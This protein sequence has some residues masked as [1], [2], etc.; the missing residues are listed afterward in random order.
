MENELIIGKTYIAS[1]GNKYVIIEEKTIKN[2]VK[3][4]VCFVETSNYQIT[5]VSTIRRGNNGL[6]DY[7]Y[8]FL[9]DVGYAIGT[10]DNPVNL[11]RDYLYT[12]WYNMILRC[13]KDGEGLKSYKKV[14]VCKEWHDYMN[15]KR[16]YEENNKYGYMTNMS[17]DKDLFSENGNKIYSP[18]TCCFIPKE[19]NACIVG[20]NKY[21]SGNIAETSSKTIYHLSLLLKKYNNIIS[22]KVKDKL[23]NIV[24]E[25]SENFKKVTGVSINNHFRNLDIQKIDLSKIHTTALIE[26]NSNLYKFNNIKQM[27]DFISEIEQSMY[28]KSKSPL[29]EV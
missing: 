13:Y 9:F 6:R 25:Y 10:K 18:A 22:D 17:L 8:P 7:S 24:L 16:W 26:Y 20:L 29:I 12:T 21:K 27:K 11:I 15:F 1:D 28:L 23:S 14:S 5:D 4:L 19:I 3:Y 2:I